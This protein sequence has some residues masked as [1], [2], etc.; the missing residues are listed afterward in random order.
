L[1]SY[2]GRSVLVIDDVGIIPFNRTHHG[3]AAEY[4]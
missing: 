2:T 3:V 4:E 1:V